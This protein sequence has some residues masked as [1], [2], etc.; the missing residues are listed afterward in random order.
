[1]DKK[2]AKERI[3]QLKKVINHHRYLYHVLDK[4]EISPEALDSLKKELFD[5]EQ[6]FPDLISSD[7][8]TQRIGGEPLKEFHKIRHAKPMISLND[9]FSKEDVLD[10][11]ERLENFLGY[12]VTERNKKTQPLFY[13]ELKLDG[14]AIELLYKD[15]VFIQ[16]STRGDGIIGEDITQNLKTI[17]AI[18]LKLLEKDE[19]IKN[20]NKIGLDHIATSLGKNWPRELVVR[21]EALLTT[22]EFQRVNKELTAKGKKIFANPRNLAAGSIRQ[23][24]PKITALR[25]LDSNQYDII[26][27]LG[28]DTHE[29]VHDVLHAFGFKTN[30]YNKSAATIDDIFVFQDSWTKHREKLPYEIDGVVILVNDISIL[31]AG[32]VVG[33]APRAAIAYKFS[34]KEATTIVEDIV[35]QIGRTGKLTPVAVLKPVRVSGVTVSHATLHNY[36]N[37]KKLGVKIGDTVIISRAGDVIPQVIKVLQELRTGKEKEFRMPAKCPIDNSKVIQ[38][39]AYYKCSNPICGAR[40]RELLYHF[41]SR[42]GFNLDG[43]GP[44]IIDRFLDE[45][46]IGDAADIFDLKEGDIGSLERF[47][48]KSAQNIVNEVAAKKKLPL[49]R[50]IYS[51]GIDHVG[52]ESSVLLEQT[53]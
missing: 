45:G 47:G 49:H 11:L 35:V 21:G 24:D 48:E 18:P 31:E 53:I 16:G 20:L 28:I 17:D 50:F 30:K 46:L 25:K 6:K 29:H 12:K 2:Q 39:G 27:D 13:C 44:K 3:E 7:S 19:V 40:N 15:G 36:D 9:A 8:P 37:I 22:K 42:G 41:I 52:E 10:W 38:E 4:Q 32:G 23:L 34:P 1:M 26:T 5:L 14:L 33:K 43:I 51:L